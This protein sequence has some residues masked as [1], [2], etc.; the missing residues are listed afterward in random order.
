MQGFLLLFYNI[1]RH[2]N[3]FGWTL[4]HQ[5]RFDEM[6]TFLTEQTSNTIPDPTQPFYAVCVRH[7]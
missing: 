3:S 4:E 5:K 7:L 6:K 1:L 2:L